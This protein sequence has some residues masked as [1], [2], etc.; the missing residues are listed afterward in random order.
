MKCCFTPV[1]RL[2]RRLKNTTREAKW[3]EHKPIEPAATSVLARRDGRCVDQGLRP[4]PSKVVQSETRPDPA[5]PTMQ[6]G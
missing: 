2:K 3:A 4:E 1:I 5:Q 6:D